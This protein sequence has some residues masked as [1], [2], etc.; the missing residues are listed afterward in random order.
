EIG[1]LDSAIQVKLLRVLQSRE[2]YR[3]GETQPRRF[4]GKVIAATHRDLEQ[5]IDAGRFR[6]DLYYRICADRIRMPT[7]REQLAA[8]PEDL[9]KLVLIISRSV[10][11]PELSQGL[12]DEVHGWIDENLGANYPWPGNIRELE[13][14]VKN[15]LVRG[16]YDTRRVDI[17]LPDGAD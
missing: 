6:E 1:E 2:V 12:A 11:G 16:E 13:Q 7:L 9:R 8:N 15:I 14:C 3:I 5:A 4:A 10:A 17:R